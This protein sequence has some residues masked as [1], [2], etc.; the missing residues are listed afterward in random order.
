MALKF[1]QGVTVFDKSN[2]LVYQDTLTTMRT[3][4]MIENIMKSA[5]Y[6]NPNMR[7][8]GFIPAE[9]ETMCAPNRGMHDL[10]FSFISQGVGVVTWIGL[11]GDSY[12]ATIPHHG[13]IY[14]PNEGHRFYWACDSEKLYANI[15]GEWIWVGNPVTGAG[16][17]GGGGVFEYSAVVNFPATGALNTLYIATSEN[18]TYRWDNTNGKYVP[19]GR[20]YQEIKYINGGAE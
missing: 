8:I 12:I 6:D 18:A 4:S 17:S 9:P 13:Y 10:K 3:I 1:E 2:T 14:P 16:P 11:N 19:V 5:Q 20:D 7:W 15:A